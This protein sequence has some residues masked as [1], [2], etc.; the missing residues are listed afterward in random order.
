MV[1][2]EEK[3]WLIH[4]DSDLIK[5]NDAVPINHYELD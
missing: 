2:K 4:F 3:K 5:K 1:R